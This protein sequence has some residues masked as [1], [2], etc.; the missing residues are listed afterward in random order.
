M[1]AGVPSTRQTFEPGESAHAGSS[2]VTRMFCADPLMFVMKEKVEYSMPFRTVSGCEKLTLKRGSW[3]TT[4]A[5]TVPLSGK[6]VCPGDL[7]VA[8]TSTSTV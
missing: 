2:F 6:S 8:F 3:M 1:K 7:Y 5:R 4:E